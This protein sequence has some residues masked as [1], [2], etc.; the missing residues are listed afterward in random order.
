MKEWIKLKSEHLLDL[1]IFKARFEFLKN[2]RNNKEVKVTVLEANDA[3]NV[4]AF[5]PQ[6]KILII[7][8]LRFGTGQFSIEI[9]GGFIDDGEDHLT[10]AQRELREETGYSSTTWTYLGYVY[11][12]PVFMTSKIH[13][14]L[15]T[16][17]VLDQATDF[18][19]EED[20]EQF[21]W[22]KERLLDAFDKNE[23][24]HPHTISALARAALLRL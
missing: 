7:K 21:L 6:Q 2:P 12:N 15:A 18:D 17:I 14:Y 22:T 16:D 23:I 4:V 20:I 19:D 5:T 8:Q 13:H 10:A 24:T 3:V 1:K 9:P 11:A